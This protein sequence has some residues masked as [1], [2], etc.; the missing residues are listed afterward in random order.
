MT[1]RRARDREAEREELRSAAD[2]LLAG[3]PLRSESGRLTATE[4][5][6]ESGLRR[7][8]AY[9]DHRDLVEEFQARAKMQNTTP[10]AMQELADKYSEMKERLASVTNKLANEQAVS[11]ALRRIV[12]ELDLELAHTREELEQSGNITRLPA[13]RRRGRPG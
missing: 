9:G 11:G 8:V 1:S 3:T 6:R 4:L 13:A 5:L 2:R 7:D 12:A 10:A